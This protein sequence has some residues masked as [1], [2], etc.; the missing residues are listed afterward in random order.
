M[1]TALENFLSDGLPFKYL[2]MTTITRCPR[3]AN[4]I[5]KEPQTSPKP[6][7]FKYGDASEVTK[8]RTRVTLV[9]FFS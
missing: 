9:D 1:S 2:G 3:A 5:G 7:V 4:A 6:P 8:T